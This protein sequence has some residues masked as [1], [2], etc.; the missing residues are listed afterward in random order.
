[1]HSKAKGYQLSIFK[2]RKGLLLK[3]GNN[4]TAQY[5]IFGCD[6][7]FP[8]FSAEFEAKEYL[9]PQTYIQ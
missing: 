8:Q 7:V 5:A 6:V 9:P 3:T 1:M 4:R 2:M